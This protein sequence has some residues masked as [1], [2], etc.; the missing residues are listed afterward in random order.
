MMRRFLPNGIAGQFAL[1]LALALLAATLIAL[2]A[3]GVDRAR[4]D[5][6]ARVE[7]EVERIFGVLPGIEAVGPE[8]RER[9]AR[10]ASTRFARVSVDARP[11]ITETPRDI[12]SLGLARLLAERLEGRVFFA[13]VVVQPVQG[14]L[15]HEIEAILISIA[16]GDAWLNIRSAPPVDPGPGGDADVVV[17]VFGLSLVAVLGAGLLFIRRL[18][19]PLDA[20]AQAAT[21]AGQGD[22]SARVPEDGP[23]E[24]QAAAVA[25][26]AMQVA[27]AR[28]EAERMRTMGAVGHDLRTPITSLRIRAEMLE[29]AALRDSMVRTLDE[30]AVMAD[31]LV[32]FAKGSREDEAVTRIDLVGF[33][34]RLAADRGVVFAGGPDLAVRG[35]HVA[36]TRAVGNL[37]DNALRY[38]GGGTLRLAQAGDMAVITVEDD[39]PGIP[40]ERLEAVFAPFVRGDDSRSAET[41]GAGLGL[42]IA[43]T[44]I[45]GMGG[46]IRLAN[47]V[48]QGL[49]AEVRLPLRD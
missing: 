20:L 36:L 35:R 23:R 18:V 25:F 7:R 24:L 2:V 34:S 46:Q 39:G 49:L 33:L 12:R 27:I 3:Q 31:G 10:E 4:F 45:A 15:R 17:L 14:R 6:A 8:R 9:L 26:N 16:V 48:P 28:F 43:Q 37:V 1:L 30:M 40:A 19:R 44:I 47:R 42:S 29:D 32:G 11:L 41:G 13:G 21:A 38:G 5:R 22:R